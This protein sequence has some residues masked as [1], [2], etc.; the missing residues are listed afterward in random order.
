MIKM[1]LLEFG[2]VSESLGHCRDDTQGRLKELKVRWEEQ[3]S[4]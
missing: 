2:Y 3:H 4:G 1:R